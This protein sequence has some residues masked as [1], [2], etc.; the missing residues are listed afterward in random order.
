LR[1]IDDSD[2]NTA[3]HHAQ[4]TIHMQCNHIRQVDANGLQIINH[5][6]KI[7]TLTD[8][9]ASII[10]HTGSSSWTFDINVVFSCQL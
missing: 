8:Y 2:A 9:F 6:R 1:A 4:A 3:F 10:G 7:A 5:A